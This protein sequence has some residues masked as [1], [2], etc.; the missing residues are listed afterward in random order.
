MSYLKIKKGLRRNVLFS[1]DTILDYVE[2]RL[3]EEDILGFIES[4]IIDNEYGSNYNPNENSL[5][6]NTGEIFLDNSNNCPDLSNLLCQ[7]EKNI[8]FTKNA[9]L[10]NMYNLFSINHELNHIIQRK[11]R[12]DERNTLK[13]ALFTKGQT[14][15]FLDDRYFD[16]RYYENFHDKF[17]LEYNANIESYLETIHLLNAYRI[18]GLK[19]CLLKLNLIAAQ[20]IIYSYGD[21]AD[22]KVIASPI[23]NLNKL[24]DYLLELLK[25]RGLY[26]EFKEILNEEGINFDDLDDKIKKEKPTSELE[27]L[28]L[29]FPINNSTYEYI[30]DISNRKIKTLNLFENIPR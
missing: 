30:N 4:V 3:D 28:R 18:K 10:V 19:N 11:T 14:E 1:D 5:Y 15:L 13:G 25:K 20:N 27:K 9:N 24:Y 23:N 2:T 22:G 21:I 8:H 17:Y 6:I 7:L 26:N 29:G 16:A 12:Y